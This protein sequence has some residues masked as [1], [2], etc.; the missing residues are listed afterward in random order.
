MAELNNKEVST[1]ERELD[2]FLIY[3]KKYRGL[4]FNSYR[5]SFLLRR[6]KAR[7]RAKG[8]NNFLEYLRVI[9]REPQEWNNLLDNLSINVSE[10]FRDPEVFIYFKE[11]CIPELIKKQK[12]KGMGIISC[13]SC[14][15]S[16]GEEPYSLAIIFKEFLREKGEKIFIKIWGTDVDEDALRKAEEAQYAKPG[17]NKVGKKILE[18]Y[19]IPLPDDTYTV[20]DE[21]KKL[22]VFKKQNLLMDKPLN[23]MDAIFLR[24]VRIYF[25]QPQAE[26]VLMDIVGSLKKDGYLVLG[27]AETM[28]VTLKEFFE[29]VSPAN[30]IFKKILKGG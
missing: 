9:K 17:L 2:L 3:A 15:C 6:F 22:V 27:K 11:Y 24:N 28:P 8:A 19:F 5:K 7:F 18:D 14:G 26:K 30:K 20:K 13:W 29:P 12:E 21:I 16:Y 4:D 23:F 10:F 1:E 25:S